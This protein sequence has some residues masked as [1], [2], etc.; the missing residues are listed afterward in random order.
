M[1]KITGTPQNVFQKDAAALRKAADDLQGG[2]RELVKDAKQDVAAAGAH[3]DE[4]AKHLAG[5]A[6]N[7]VYATGALLE[8]TADVLGAAGHA[9]AA[10][11]YAAVGTAGWIAEGISS[12]GRF[13]AKNLARGFAAIANAMTNVLKDGKFT[14][15][16]E[17]AG[18]PNAVRFSDEMFGKAAGQL[19]KSADLMN[20]AWNSYVEC[21]DHMAGAGANVAYAAGHT[22]AVIGHLGKAAAEIGASGVVELAALGAEAAAV[23]VEYAE[24]GFAGARD[25]A[26]LAAKISAATANALAIA[27]QGEVKVD[28]ADKIKGFQQELKAL[29][30]A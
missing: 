1:T 15:V 19:N 2:A 23:A 8:G 26:I 27:G 5:A 4:A 6:A 24:K 20:A 7:A 13:V 12:A 18:D 11:A 17:L 14:T 30:A 9:G 3:A 25:A 29:Q 21:I 22:A 28:V 10:G 16:R